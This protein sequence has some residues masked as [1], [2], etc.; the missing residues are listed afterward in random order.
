MSA[1][2]LAFRSVALATRPQT[3]GA[4]ATAPRA[5]VRPIHSSSA[6]V[7]TM[8]RPMRH[9]ESTRESNSSLPTSE[10]LARLQAELA[11]GY[12]EVP[13][14]GITLK[15]L[16]GVYA[17]LFREGRERMFDSIRSLFRLHPAH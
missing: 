16:I 5:F 14:E 3:A 12:M 15:Q 6:K 9:R 1:R 10:I 11:E 8:S 17:E 13:V 4:L 2:V 7:L